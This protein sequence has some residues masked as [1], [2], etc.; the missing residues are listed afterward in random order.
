M[1]KDKQKPQRKYYEVWGDTMNL[2][3]FLRTIVII[4]SALCIYLALML[5]KASDKLPLVIK[6]DE[7]GQVQAVPNWQSKV[8]VSEPEIA[9]FTQTF[10]ELFTAYDFYTYDDSFRKAFKM[11]TPQYQKKADEFMQ[12][13]RTVESIQQAQYKTK[14]NISKIEILK[15]TPQNVILKIKGYREQRSYLNPD[16]YK[17][18]IFESELVLSKI[19]RD[20]QKPWGL[21][22]ENYSET[23]IKE[24]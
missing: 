2:V 3:Y 17:E 14:V 7:I 10:M 23:I 1:T 8:A 12:S 15:D 4:L 21:L 16:F 20:F 13:N 9:N 24:K 5:K 11:M 6:V 22:V 18:I 19:K